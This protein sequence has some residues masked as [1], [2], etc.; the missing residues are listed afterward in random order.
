MPAIFP[1][2][3]GQQ[4]A[5]RGHVDAPADLGEGQALAV[6]QVK[7]LL[8]ADVGAWPWSAL[9]CA[10][11]PPL[12]GA[13]GDAELGGDGVGG[14]AQAVEALGLGNLGLVALRSEEHT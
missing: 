3:A 5:G 11:E 7:D 14:E 4:G 2:L 6:A 10:A 1:P 12:D 9:V 13:R 8:V